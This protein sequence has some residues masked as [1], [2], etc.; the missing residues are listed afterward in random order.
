VQSAAKAPVPEP[1]RAAPEPPKPAPEPA[2]AA[3]PPRLAAAETIRPVEPAA[4][5]ASEPRP[6]ESSPAFSASAPGLSSA[7]A[8]GTQT[9]AL[10][11]PSYGT[12]AAGALGTGAGGRKE[13]FG[14]Y[15][16]AATQTSI[17]A[18]NNTA[19]RTESMKIEAARA[20]MAAP[21]AAVAMRYWEAEAVGESKGMQEARAAIS[22][23]G[24]MAIGL[25]KQLRG[26]K[27]PADRAT[28][29]L[30]GSITQNSADTGAEACAGYAAAA[31]AGHAPAQ[32]HAALCVAQRDPKQSLAWLHAAA[33]AGHAGAQETLG[34][35]CIEGAEKN[36][37]CAGLY[38]ERAALRGRA[39]AMTLY[40]WVLSNQPAASDKDYADAVG[41]YR[42]GAG[43]GDLFAQNNLGEMYER[44]RGVERDERLAR[45][46]YGR[47]A[48][49]DFG[50]GQFNYAR[51][52]LAGIGGPV[53]RNGA[54]QWL[55]KA[56]KN[57]VQQAKAALQQLSASR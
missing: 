16:A 57:G 29:A 40:G 12:A 51:M 39:S 6:A 50:P 38:F 44:G 15:S 17:N 7:P 5:A 43:A 22:G 46:W 34:R 9:A 31:A 1:P 48:E 33:D 56:E 49:A 2:R 36:W 3:E 24:P 32:Y 19:R 35:A 25:A 8:G 27:T 26:S 4:S 23:N 21:L 13:S 45:Q 53:D 14:S 42:K 52:L 55:Q 20:Q 10:G 11:R 37:G 18:L 28:A 54:V 41:W 30:L 47:A